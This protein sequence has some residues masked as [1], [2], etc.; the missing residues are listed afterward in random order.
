PLPCQVVLAVLAYG[1][2]HSPFRPLWTLG[3]NN[4]PSPY[5][6]SRSTVKLTP[7][8]T[9]WC[10]LTKQDVI[11][12]ST[13]LA[14]RKRHTA[15]ALAARTEP[16]AASNPTPGLSGSGRGILQISVGRFVGRP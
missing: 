15:A 13:L 2:T 7:I 9:L 3:P 4:Q 5:A 14:G 16:P 10:L 8:D 11:V 12:R 1:F 6:D